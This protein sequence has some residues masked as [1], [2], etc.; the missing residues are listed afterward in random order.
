[1]IGA[2]TATNFDP[3][4]AFSGSDSVLL[5]SRNTPYGGVPISIPGTLEVEKYD[6]GGAE[7]AYH[8]TSAGTHG[9]DYDNPPNY[10]PPSYRQ[11]T[12]VD[13]YKSAGGYS[14][15][16]LIVM[17]AG[18]WMNYSVNIAQAASYNLTGRVAWGGATGGTFHVEVDGLDVTGAMQIPDTGWSLVTISKAGI[19]LPAGNHVMRVVA[20]T[21]AANGCIGDID[22]LSLTVESGGGISPDATTSF[23]VKIT[24]DELPNNTVVADQYLNQYGVRFAS[25]NFAAPVHTKQ[26]C[27]Q[28]CSPVSFPNFISTKPDDTGQLIVTFAQPVSNLVF[29]AVGVDTLSGTFAFVDLYRNGSPVPSNTFALNGVFSTTVGFS[30]GSLTNIDKVV[31]RGINDAL[32][33]GFDDFS[34]NVPA[35]VQ[36][37]NPR[38][39]GSLN[40]TTQSS[41]LGANVTLSGAPKPGAF[42]GGTYNWT[43]TG[44]AYSITGGSQN[45]SSITIRPTNV[46][47]ITAKLTYTRNAVS[48]SPSVNINVIM[49]TLTSFW[50][51]ERPD[52][53]NRNLGCSDTEGVGYTLGCQRGEVED[54]I[55]WH[56]TAQIPVGS[57]LS[58]PA[59]AGIKF[60]QSGSIYRKRLLDGNAQCFTTRTPNS[61]GWYLDGSDPYD[62]ARNRYFSEGYVLTDMHDFDPPG[63]SVEYPDLSD[64]PRFPDVSMDAQLVDDQFET[65]VV[66]FTTVATAHDAEH[67]IFQRIIGFQNSNHPFAALRWR[68]GGDVVF[69]YFS[70]PPNLLY[71]LQSN[72]PT[73][74]IGA[75]ETDTTKSLV[76]PPYSLT[77]IAPCA[78]TTVTTNPIDGARFY[79]AQLYWDLLGRA[80]DQS[81][82]NFWRSYITRC[83]F[84]LACIDAERAHVALATFYSTE[85]ISMHP[86]I[87]GQRGTHDYNSAFVLWVY[88]GLLQREPNAPPDNNWDG[89]NFWVGVLDGT[90]PDAG[91]YKYSQV[92]K[93]FVVSTEYRNRF[94]AH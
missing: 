15:G 65:Y 73:G 6:N 3:T 44:P 7:V 86:E 13:I 87:G 91:D 52:Q 2:A 80:P 32:G 94:V 12:D 5:N 19:Q 68:W 50:G 62:A 24:F 85:F 75:V 76:P 71:T 27:G 31:I 21:N 41:L 20:D 29:Y 16:Y 30:S 74:T 9:Q 45:S 11:P 38:A 82:W 14:N 63:L 64:H 17:Q 57:Y 34:F 77:T 26:D 1:V 93:G 8:D 92:L 40:G 22:Y 88:R 69:N 39:N 78:G 23:P 47:T 59:E 55:I 90:N 58:D 25:A 10:P 28:T 54:G 46:G 84:D 60:V 48:V 43:L 56:A 18:D 35:D 72:T 4:I 33:I 89:Y 49:P 36:I 66:Y 79:T 70:N 51:D 81:G 83:G 42:A 61:D 67:P 37:T 53:L